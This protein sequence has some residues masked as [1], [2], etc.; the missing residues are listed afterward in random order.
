MNIEI[1]ASRYA[2]LVMTG[3]PF[4]TGRKR[5][6]S[7]RR[8]PMKKAGPDGRPFDKYQDDQQFS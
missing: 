7:R 2:L 6:G 4:S 3:W 8:I 5:R 1:A